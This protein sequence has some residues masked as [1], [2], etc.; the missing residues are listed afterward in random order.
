V[1]TFKAARLSDQDVVARYVA[2]EARGMISLRAGKPDAWVVAILQAAGIPLRTPAES[3]AILMR[4]RAE[5]QARQG[6]RVVVFPPGTTGRK[7]RA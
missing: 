5:T 6:R 4:H 3:M 2:G 1:G 7:R